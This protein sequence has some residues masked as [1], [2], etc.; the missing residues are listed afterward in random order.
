MTECFYFIPKA[1]LAAVLVCAVAFMVDVGTVRRLWAE[2]RVELGALALTFV[3]GVSWSVELALLC[4]ALASLAAVLHG[5]MCPPAP[6][7][8]H[9]VRPCT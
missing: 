5:L 3:V 7:R 4:G 8:L 1:G 6:L 2:G 9:K